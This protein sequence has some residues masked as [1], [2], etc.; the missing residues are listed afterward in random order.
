[1]PLVV[2]VRGD[3]PS[4]ADAGVVDDDIER[5]E[6]LYDGCDGRSHLVGARHVAGDREL[7]VRHPVGGAV[8]H[9]HAGSAFGGDRGGR[10]AGPS[11][12]SDRLPQGD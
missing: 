8:E 2:V 6:V 5:S 1:M 10:G 9:C 4:C 7:V 12:A 3:V 11:A